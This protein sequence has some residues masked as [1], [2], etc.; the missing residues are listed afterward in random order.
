MASLNYEKNYTFLILSLFSRRMGLCPIPH[1]FISFACPK[2][3]NQRK[4]Q[5]QI[6]FGINILSAAH[7][8]Q[9]VGLLTSFRD[10]LK[11][12]CLLRPCASQPPKCHSISK[13]DLVA[14]LVLRRS[15]RA[16]RQTS[17]SD[18]QPKVRRPKAR[19]HH[20]IRGAST[21]FHDCTLCP[22]KRSEGGIA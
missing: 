19:H 5:P 1:S 13:K 16:N 20:S 15:D 6:F 3:T 2:E 9:L 7:A 14:L 11:Q 8:I 22:P 21:R 12:Y 17:R 4:G 10:L 18:R